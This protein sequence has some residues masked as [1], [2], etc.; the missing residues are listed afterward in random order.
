MEWESDGH[1]VPVINK[2]LSHHIYIYILNI[3]VPNSFCQRFPVTVHGTSPHMFCGILSCNVHNGSISHFR[4]ILA[5]VCGTG[6]Q[7]RGICVSCQLM[8]AGYIY[9]CTATGGWVRIRRPDPPPKKCTP[10]C[11][12]S[13]TGPQQVTSIS[14]C[15]QRGSILEVAGLK[16]QVIKIQSPASP[17]Q[18]KRREALQQCKYAVV[19]LMFSF[20]RAFR[21]RQNDYT[22][23]PYSALHHSH[24]RSN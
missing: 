6:T 24:T 18:Q 14:Q 22:T 1:R 23:F 10:H 11:I 16:G 4:N 3:Y 5:G 7:Y 17:L 13:T 8:I 21:S 2:L 20:F 12:M 19:V 9:S 15:I